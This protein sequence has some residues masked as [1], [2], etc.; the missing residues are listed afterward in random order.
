MADFHKPGIYGTGRVWTNA[1]DVFR[2]TPSRSG[3]VR[4]A[5]V[6]FVVSFG[7]GGNSCYFVVFFF[8]RT[9]PAAS[10]RP[11][12][13]VYL[14]TVRV[15]MTSVPSLARSDWMATLLLW[16]YRFVTCTA[17]ICL[18]SRCISS[19]PRRLSGS[20]S[21]GVRA[22]KSS[23]TCAP[24]RQKKSRAA[25]TRSECAGWETKDD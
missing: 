1:W 21:R 9:R 2:C 8:K 14:S 5:T 16:F 24:V 7:W 4:R 17:S 15:L 20:W 12:C 22:N 10:M 6:D 25:V 23:C 19:N 13:L 11:P 3:R 18:D